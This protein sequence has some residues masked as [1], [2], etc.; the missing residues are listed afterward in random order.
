VAWASVHLSVCL[1]VHHTLPLYQNGDTQNHEIFTVGC[2]KVSSFS[3]ESWQNF[4]PLGAGV[5]LERGRQIGWYPL[6]DVILSLLAHIVWKRLQIGTDMLHIITSTG[7][8]LFRFIN[9]NDLERPWTSKSG[10]LLIFSQ[11]LDATHIS[12]L[13]CDEIARDK[14]TCVWNFQH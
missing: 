3:W 14:T 10:F 1:S 5:P 11:F 13:N 7:D 9:I 6:K 2:L 8:R 4:A 12:T